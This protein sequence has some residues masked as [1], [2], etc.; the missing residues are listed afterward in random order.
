[1]TLKLKNAETLTAGFLSS[2]NFAT[3]VLERVILVNQPN[4]GLLSPFL[5]SWALVGAGV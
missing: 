2:G 3:C 1:M 5:S 4:H